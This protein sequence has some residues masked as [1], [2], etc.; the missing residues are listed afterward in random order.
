ML[1]NVHNTLISA[2]IASPITG[3]FLSADTHALDLIQTYYQ[4]LANDDAY[5]SARYA[6]NTGAKPSVQERAGLLPQRSV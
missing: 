2:L 3:S 6:L 1:R 4:A 5:T